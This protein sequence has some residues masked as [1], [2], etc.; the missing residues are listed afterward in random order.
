MNKKTTKPESFEDFKNS[1][2][3][4]SRTDLNFKFLSNLTPELAADFFQQLLWKIGD[5]FDDKDFDG[6]IEHVTEWQMKAYDS[7]G[8]WQYDDKPF[9]RPAKPVSQMKLTLLTSTGHFARG[10]DPEPLGRKNMTQE[11]AIKTIGETIKLQPE[12]SKIPFD[13][14]EK[15]IMVRHAGYDIRGARANSNVCFPYKLLN[16]LHNESVIGS[17][18]Q[19]AYSFVGACSQLLLNQKSVPEWTKAFQD[20][21]I[22]A[23]IIIPV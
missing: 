19:Y 7:K 18:S 10:D 3:Y 12:L 14:S 4:G 21:E 5:S 22:E 13:I 6:I 9:A 2:S 11:E 17:L 23:V 1:F 20:E 15:D 8:K 16:R